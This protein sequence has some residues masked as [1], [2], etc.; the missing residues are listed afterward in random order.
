MAWCGILQL[1]AFK[2]SFLKDLRLLY[3]IKCAEIIAQIS[4]D[5]IKNIQ[6]YLTLTSNSTKNSQR[7]LVSLILVGLPMKSYIVCVKIAYI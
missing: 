4:F 6:K 3:F 1:V 7:L 2:I 5:E